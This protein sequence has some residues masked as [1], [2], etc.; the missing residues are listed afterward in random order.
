MKKLWI[1]MLVFFLGCSC[2]VW[3]GLDDGLI[4]Y[5][6]FNNCDARDDSGNGYNGIIHGDPECIDGKNGAALKLNELNQDYILVPKDIKLNIPSYTISAWSK[7]D[8]LMG[9]G[10]LLLAE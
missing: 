2:I 10:K 7:I 5:W 8:Q 3:A 6:S 9:S 1:L 4:A